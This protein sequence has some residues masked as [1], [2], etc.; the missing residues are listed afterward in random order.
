MKSKKHTFPSYFFLLKEK[1][2]ILLCKKKYE[3]IDFSPF[4]LIVPI[5]SHEKIVSPLNLYFL[6]LFCE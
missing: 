3:E 6:G 1:L 5:E 2:V 4:N